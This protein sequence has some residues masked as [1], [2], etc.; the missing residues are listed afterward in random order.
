MTIDSTSLPR[1]AAALAALAIGACAATDYNYSQLY[2]RRY[3]KAPIDTYPVTIL[4]VDGEDFL[5]RPVLVSPGT[6]KI[7]V[8]GP[9][10][11]TGGV[12]D[13]QQISMEIAPCTRYFLVAVKPSPLQSSFAVRVDYQE[14]VGGCTPPKAS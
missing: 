2:G 11:G 4:R 6:R 8:Q 7:T 10:G 9:P 1:V 3:F 12:G 13:Q 14:P 5:N